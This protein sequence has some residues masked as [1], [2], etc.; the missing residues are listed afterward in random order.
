MAIKIYGNWTKGFSLDLHT[1]S[2][3]YL[4][5]DDFGHDRFET[6][7]TKVGELLYKL[8][9]KSDKTVI[10]DIINAIKISIQNI[11][12]MDFIVPVPPS[13]K[14]RNYQPV[15]EIG[16][17]LSQ[18]TGVPFIKNALSKKSSNELKN[19]TDINERERI[20]KESISLKSGIDFSGKK[21][22]VIDDLY[23]SGATLRAV[24]SVILED[25]N[26]KNVFVLTLTK[27]RSKT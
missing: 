17:S 21:V 2:S 5:V 25:G 11:D 12:K 1:E 26:A 20:L 6:K 16:K 7:R 8:K 14:T 23:R 22:L 13:N 15:Y 24:T 4:G 19:V 27:T 10:P 3:E 18:D 9:Y